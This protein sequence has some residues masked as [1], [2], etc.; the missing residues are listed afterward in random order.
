MKKLIDYVPLVLLLALTPFFYYNQPNIAQSIMVA[1]ITGL[2]GY[3][4]Y[5]ESLRKPNYVEIF[6]SR[7]NEEKDSTDKKL[8]VLLKEIEELKAT[9]GKLNI[10]RSTED[11]IKNFKW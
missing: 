7:L 4:A 2:V 10:V 6:T 1:A 9:Q 8:N 11:K 5:L 3:K